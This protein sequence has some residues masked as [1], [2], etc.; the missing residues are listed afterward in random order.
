MLNIN[1]KPEDTRVVVAMSGGVDSS[2]VAALVKE[3]G[4][5]VIGMTMQ[6]YD[7]GEAT[8]RSKACC[9]GQD[10]KDARAV[11]DKIGIPHYVLNY[12]SLFKESVIE[13]FA[14]SY[15]RGE[16]PI[17]CVRCNQTVKFRDMLKAAKDLNADA[18]VTGHYI[19]RIDGPDGPELHRGADHGKDQSYFL[20]TTTREQLEYL[21]FPL[22]GMSKEETRVHAQRL[23]LPVADKPD[24]QDICFVPNGNYAKI[25]EKLRPEAFDPGEMVHVDGQVMGQHN[26]IAN[27]TVGQGKGLGLGYHEKLYVIKIDAAKKRVIVGPKEA[28]GT[29]E[30]Y[31]KE[32]NWLGK[33]AIENELEVS[34]KIRSVH[35][36]VPATILVS[37]H[38]SSG[39]AKATPDRPVTKIV[40]HKAED[41]VTPGQACVIYNGERVMGGGWITP[42]HKE[43]LKLAA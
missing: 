7:Q 29:T 38:Q 27:F 34:V 35:E 23:G 43:N 3:Q 32:L 5:D 28:L 37:S 16:T 18:L 24:S 2:T 21:H 15:L 22:G 12:E 17:P 39:S 4:Y 36:P 30:F 40:L 42:D 31:I 13:D 11:A 9:A 41:A 20:F 26:G 19:Q 25:I 8:S 6:L 1:K 33:S 10:I 14:D